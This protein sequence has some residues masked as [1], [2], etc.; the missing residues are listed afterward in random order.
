MLQKG[1]GG[2]MYVYYIDS[3]KGCKFFW[4]VLSFYTHYTLSVPPYQSLAA[5]SGSILE[6]G[7]N[8]ASPGIS[9]GRIAIVVVSTPYI[10]SYVTVLPYRWDFGLGNRTRDM[11]PSFLITTP[12]RWP[13]TYSFRWVP[14]H[15]NPEKHLEKIHW[16][17][18]GSNPGRLISSLTLYLLCHRTPHAG[19]SKIG[20][21]FFFN[22]IYDFGRFLCVWSGAEAIIFYI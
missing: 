18:P 13:L 9:I 14:N 2:S 11:L 8:R 4:K 1:A 6:A 17:W 12:R 7:A 15:Q 5:D 22:H 20:R 10:W 3:P 19:G 21:K 16:C